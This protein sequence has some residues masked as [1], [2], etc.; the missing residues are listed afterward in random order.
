MDNS[1]IYSTAAE[2]RA[3]S[4]TLGRQTLC[5]YSTDNW[6]ELFTRAEFSRRWTDGTIFAGN[7]N[8][9]PWAVRL[10][11]RRPATLAPLGKDL[12]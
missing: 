10:L 8:G 2:A 1:P 4:L 5:A 9:R 7:I 12:N 11:P 6:G 3:A